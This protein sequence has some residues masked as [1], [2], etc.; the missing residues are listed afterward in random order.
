MSTFRNVVSAMVGQ[1]AYF[2]LGDTPIKATIKKINDDLAV[3]KLSTPMAGYT[4]L[5]LHIDRLILVTA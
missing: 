1:E 3:L 5:A 2:L 4:E